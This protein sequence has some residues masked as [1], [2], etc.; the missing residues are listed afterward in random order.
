[1]LN[2][3]ASRGHETPAV[4]DVFQIETD[5]AGLFVCFQIVQGV[6]FIHVDLVT[7]TQTFGE[8]VDRKRTQIFQQGSDKGPGLRNNPNRTRT[9]HVVVAEIRGRETGLGIDDA[10][11]VGS[12]TAHT[13][14]LEDGANFCL[15]SASFLPGLCEPF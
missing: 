8:P 6:D 3:L 2:R 15:N 7:Q 9:E 4:A 13:R 11:G 1:M 14:G 10:Q 5:D 12:E